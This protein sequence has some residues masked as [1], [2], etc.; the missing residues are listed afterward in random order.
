LGRK[1]GFENF[2]H[3]EN[4]FCV[5]CEKNQCALEINFQHLVILVFCGLL[6]GEGVFGGEF[7][8]LLVI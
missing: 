4:K 2:V 1:T 3:L 5:P 8:C 7:I 6:G